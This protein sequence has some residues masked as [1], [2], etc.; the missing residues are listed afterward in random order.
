MRILICSS[1]SVSRLEEE[2]LQDVVGDRDVERAPT[3][4]HRRRPQRR[5]R[6]RS[7]SNEQLRA[8]YPLVVGVK[9][10]RQPAA[11]SCYESDIDRV[12]IG[13]LGPFSGVGL[14]GI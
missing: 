7:K 8:A 11:A 9:K 12:S 5:R 2:G 4:V 10:R 1:S 13:E 6:G 3:L 14:W